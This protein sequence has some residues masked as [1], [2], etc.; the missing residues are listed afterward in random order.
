MEVAHNMQASFDGSALTEKT[1]RKW[2]VKFEL[3]NMGFED[4]P[5]NSMDKSLKEMI[6]ADPKRNCARDWNF[7][8][9]RVEWVELKKKKLD[10]YISQE[11][12][13]QHISRPVAR[14]WHDAKKSFF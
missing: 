12:T 5:L 7:T 14:Y 9:Y 13:G 6:E 11:L 8:S 2:F 3:W 4:T 10:K 1:M